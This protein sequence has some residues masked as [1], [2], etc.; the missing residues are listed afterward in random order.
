[1]SLFAL[2][3]LCLDSSADD[4][5]KKFDDMGFSFQYPAEWA[6]H[7]A[8][9]GQ[10]HED[11]EGNSRA[12]GKLELDGPCVRFSINWTRDPGISPETIL[13]QIEKTYDSGEVKVLSSERGEVSMKGE[14]ARVM[15]L[16]YELKG[17]SSAKRFAVWNTSRSDRIFLASISRSAGCSP[18]LEQST[19]SAALFDS[20]VA[21]FSDG[22]EREQLMLG[23]KSKDEAWTLVL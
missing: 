13:G 16:S 19:A 3:V 7:S 18:E 4:D 22:G 6:V 20:L 8:S 10:G 9:D 17:C 2:N 23:P 1:M 14:R 15:S 11:E 5:V 12:A 21:S